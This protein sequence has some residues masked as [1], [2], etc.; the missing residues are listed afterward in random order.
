[1]TKIKWF[2]EAAGLESGECRCLG[3]QGGISLERPQWKEL[4]LML[5]TSCTETKSPG[6][7]RN[8][9][10]NAVVGYP[11]G[12]E[13]R[14]IWGRVSA[15]DGFP[16][17]LAS[18]ESPCNTGDPGLIPGSGRFPREGNGNPSQYSC[19][20]NPMDRGAWWGHKESDTTK[21]RT[22]SQ[23][24]SAEGEEWNLGTSLAVQRLRLCTST[25]GT[26]NSNPDPRT[27]ILHDLL[28]LHK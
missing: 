18:K 8:Q 19:L 22:L 13:P 4:L 26:L 28:S 11:L 9:W 10:C 27:K 7:N 3:Y 1:M 6:I 25:A 20:E 15:K 23:Y 2:K 21:R 16:G 5:M 24:V 14:W 12:E 17:A